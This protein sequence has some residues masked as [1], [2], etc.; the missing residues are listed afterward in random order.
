MFN[1]TVILLNSRLVQKLNNLCIEKS[2]ELIQGERA[3]YLKFL[4]RLRNIGM[5]RVDIKVMIKDLYELKYNVGIKTKEIAIWIV[6]SELEHAGDRF[7]D[8][9]VCET[10][11]S[12]I[13]KNIEDKSYINKF[14]LEL[15]RVVEKNK[16]LILSY[17]EDNQK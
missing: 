9:I 5:E 17:A 16:G 4:M 14:P 10:I 7:I 11:I 15:R 8:S 12:D 3:D 2:N 1:E 6:V 13:A